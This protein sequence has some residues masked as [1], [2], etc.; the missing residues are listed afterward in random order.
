[1]NP[2]DILLGAQA[3]TGKS[4]ARITEAGRLIGELQ[5]LKARNAPT[6]AV[7]IDFATLNGEQLIEISTANSFPPSVMAYYF[8]I[9]PKTNHA[10][11][12]KIFKEDGKLTNEIYSDMLMG[13]PKDLGLPKDA[14][15]LNIIRNG[16]LSPA[17]SAYEQDEHGK[18]DNRLN[19]II[20]RWNGKFYARTSR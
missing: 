11:P 4:A 15:E 8:V 6:S 19:R 20:Y 13:E 3:R 2:R 1:M 18:I 14:T 17:F 12:K 5:A 16:R 10:V 7:D 9:D